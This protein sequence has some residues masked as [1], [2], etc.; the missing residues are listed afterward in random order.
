MPIILKKRLFN[1][2]NQRGITLIE[3]I[4]VILIIG[5]IAAVGIPVV[6]NQ[7]ANAK[8]K[9]DIANIA[10]MHEALERYATIN[11]SYPQL[12]PVITPGISKDSGN[13]ALLDHLLKVLTDAETWILGRPYLRADFP[14]TDSNGNLWIVHVIPF[15]AANNIYAIDSI[16]KQE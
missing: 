8:E 14:R 9:Q 7:I 16:S 3:L 4:A 1:L 12:D 15:D 5:I 13:E 10:I 2:F 11:R 6:F